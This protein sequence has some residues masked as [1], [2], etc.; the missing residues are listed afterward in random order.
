MPVLVIL[1]EQDKI[2]G[3][4]RIVDKFVMAEKPKM[5]EDSELHQL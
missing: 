1:D 5:R 2:H 3:D 4:C